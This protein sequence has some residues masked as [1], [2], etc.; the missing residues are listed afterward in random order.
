MYKWILDGVKCSKEAK[1]IFPQQEDP[2]MAMILVWGDAF[3]LD[4]TPYVRVALWASIEFGLRISECVAKRANHY[5]T[6]G[7]A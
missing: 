4:A 3:V 6:R 2:L 5:L 1:G 7:D